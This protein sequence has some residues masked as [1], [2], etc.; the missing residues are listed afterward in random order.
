VGDHGAPVFEAA[1]QHHDAGHR[2]ERPG[3]R[4]H[5]RALEHLGDQP[6]EQRE[7]GDADGGRGEADEHRASDAP[8]QALGKRP[9]S[10]V[11]IHA[12][13]NLV[14]GGA[15]LLSGIISCGAA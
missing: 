3:E 4:V 6:T 8:T 11:E 1:A 5:A 13:I 12:G 15:L 9:Q 7:P 14:R 10:P 2:S